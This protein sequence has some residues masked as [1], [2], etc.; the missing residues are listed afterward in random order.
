MVGLP[1]SQHQVCACE[2]SSWKGHSQG[3]KRE[4]GREVIRNYL[5][6]LNW[7]IRDE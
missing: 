4:T 5:A 3:G 1:I 7:L 2:V 6:Q